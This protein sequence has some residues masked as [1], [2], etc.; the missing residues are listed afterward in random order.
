VS[1]SDEEYLAL[2]AAA[3]AAEALGQPVDDVLA[4]YARATELVPTRA[5]ALHG[6]SR[7]CARHQRHAEG[8]AL[9][10]RGLDLAPP[11]GAAHVDESVYRY[12]LLDA[13]S[14]NAFGLRRFEDALRACVQILRVAGLPDETRARVTVNARAAE[15]MLGTGRARF[16]AVSAPGAH[17]PGAPR[18]LASRLPD[19]APRVLLAILAKQQEPVLDLYLRCIEALDYPKSSIVVHVRTNNNTDRTREILAAWADRVRSDYAAVELDDADV[20]ERVQDFGLHE[21]NPERFRVLARIRDA[22]LAKAL[23]HG[24]A[25]YFTADVDNFVIP[26]TLRELVALGLPIVAPMLRTVDPTS[27]YSNLHADVDD[28]GYFAECQQYDW[29]LSQA[30]TGIFELPVV[31]CTYLIRADVVPSLGYAD[32]TGRHEYV[33]FSERARRAGIPQYFDNRQTYGYLLFEPEREIDGATRLMGPYLP[34]P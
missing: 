8:F 33:V 15:T 26:S 27:R 9:A 17:A 11:A 22:S 24:C 12:G 10:A 21:W 6:A 25:Y 30:V 34:P 18:V 16:S 28:N 13:Y 20:P 7:L 31:H 4:L 3:E 2:V 23:A 32:A 5:E 29:I 1:T 14:A 19:P